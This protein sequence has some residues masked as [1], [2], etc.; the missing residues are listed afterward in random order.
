[1]STKLFGHGKQKLQTLNTA[2]PIYLV[3]SS[4]PQDTLRPVGT[5]HGLT[6][7]YL[8]RRRLI[9]RARMQTL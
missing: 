3:L 5:Y 7:R 9:R 6:N 1:M 2:Q 4:E 8:A